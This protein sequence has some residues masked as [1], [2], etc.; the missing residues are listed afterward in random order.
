MIAVCLVSLSL[1]QS[2][3]PMIA[4][5]STRPHDRGR[6]RVARICRTAARKRATARRRIP[7]GIPVSD[8]LYRA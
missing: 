6:S 2:I 4:A 7:V 5:I 3:K 8:S 1:G